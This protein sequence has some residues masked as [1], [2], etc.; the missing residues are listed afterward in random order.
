MM[1]N[2]WFRLIS[3]EKLKLIIPNKSHLWFY[4]KW[5]WLQRII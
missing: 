1:T 3:K 4:Q 5:N 2:L